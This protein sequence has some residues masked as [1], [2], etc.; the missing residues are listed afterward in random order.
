[1]RKDGATNANT[2]NTASA[3]SLT[4][5]N[6]LRQRANNGST[7]ANVNQSQVNLDFIIDE[8]ARELHWEG[9]RRQDLICFNKYG[10]VAIIGLGK[11]ILLTE[12]LW[13]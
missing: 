1:M 6:A 2:A 4:Y 10:G 8:R 13:N 12:L 9:H 11:E 3:Q 5:I 7:V